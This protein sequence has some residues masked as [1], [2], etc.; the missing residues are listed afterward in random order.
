M[1]DPEILHHGRSSKAKTPAQRLLDRP[2]LSN[3]RACRWARKPR[4]PMLS[5][6][7]PP[8]GLVPVTSH[9]VARRP[10]NLGSIAENAVADIGV[11][12]FDNASVEQP[13]GPVCSGDCIG[14]ERFRAVLVLVELIIGS[15]SALVNFA[16]K[17][18]YIG[19]KLIVSIR[20]MNQ[21]K[22]MAALI[23][24]HVKTEVF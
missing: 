4:R 8:F 16:E 17:G 7:T 15:F 10:R 22:A 24:R 5:I 6:A 14:G 12:W 20:Q 1:A 3:R 11:D 19:C 21:D 23:L 9:L 2:N 13:H 18:C